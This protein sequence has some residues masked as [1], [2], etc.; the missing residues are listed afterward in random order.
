MYH[1]IHISVLCV[2]LNSLQTPHDI[3]TH[4]T[5]LHYLHGTIIHVSKDHAVCRFSDLNTSN[6]INVIS[7]CYVSRY[8]Y[9]FEFCFIEERDF[10]LSETLHH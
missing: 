8:M 6:T 5:H 10:C 4:S 1:C 2:R 3:P 9:V 7:E